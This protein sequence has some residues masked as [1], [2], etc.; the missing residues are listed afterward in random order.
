MLNTLLLRVRALGAFLPST[1]RTA[2]SVAPFTDALRARRGLAHDLASVAALGPTL[3]DAGEAQQRRRQL[4]QRPPRGGSV[5]S[6]PRAGRMQ[7]EAVRGGDLA[8]RGGRVGA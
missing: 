6:G 8:A 2:A 1:R 7:P 5:A 3:V 4:P